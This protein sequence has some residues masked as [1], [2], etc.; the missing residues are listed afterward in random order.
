M[1]PWMTILHLETTLGMQGSEK[2]ENLKLILKSCHVVT[3]IM[4]IIFALH[5]DLHF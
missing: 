5:I 4:I 3:I 2:V 1:P